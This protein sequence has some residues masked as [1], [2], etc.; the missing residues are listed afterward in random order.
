MTFYRSIEQLPDYEDYSMKGRSYRFFSGEPLYPFGYGLSYTSFSY[1]KAK[2]SPRRITIPVS[3]T[4]TRDG[5][6]TVQLYVRRPGDADGPKLSLRGFRRVAI[7]AGRTVE[8]TFPLTG[9]TFTWWSE[10]AGD[11]IPLKGE[12]ELLYGGSS[13]A[14]Q[15]CRIKR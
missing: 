5:V 12:W 6:E 15:I 13:D 3:N 14:L 4:G 1:G 9:E 11:M 10:E 8:V 7:P 2:V